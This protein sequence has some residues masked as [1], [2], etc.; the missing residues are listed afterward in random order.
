VVP[1]VL[2]P[3]DALAFQSAVIADAVLAGAVPDEIRT[4]FERLHD[5][6]KRGVIDYGNFAEVCNQAIA[7]YEPALRRRFIQFYQARDIPFTERDGTAAPLR[8][9]DY[10]A[11]YQ[12]V[13]PTKGKHIQGPSGR[14]LRGEPPKSRRSRWSSTMDYGLKPM[15]GP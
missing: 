11:V 2:H 3:D 14:G 12:H 6:H 10:D 15:M 1:G 4:E 9:N 13:G 7:L 5:K 8:T